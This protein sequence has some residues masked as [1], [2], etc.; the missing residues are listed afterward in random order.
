LTY[1]AV[2]VLRVANV[3]R[4]ASWYAAVLG[5]TGDSVGPPA[6]PV[7]AILHR[8]DVELMLQKVRPGVPRVQPLVPDVGPI[9]DREYGCRELA[10]LDP[11]GHVVVLGE[12]G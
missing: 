1:S 4:S 2:P 8:D 10:I 6:D 12:C 7:F 5:F 9:E 3:A 11:D